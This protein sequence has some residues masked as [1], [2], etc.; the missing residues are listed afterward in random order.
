MQKYELRIRKLMVKVGMEYL[1]VRVR[2][3][4]EVYC[5]DFFTVMDF[6]PCVAPKLLPNQKYTKK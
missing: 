2:V 4:V 1:R 5:V 6:L 3:L